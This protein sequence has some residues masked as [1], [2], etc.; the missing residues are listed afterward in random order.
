MQRTLA[1]IG[2]FSPYNFNISPNGSRIS[3]YGNSNGLCIS[4]LG[5]ERGCVAVDSP[6]DLTS[7]NNDGEVLVFSVVPGVCDHETASNFFETAPN[8]GR[9][10]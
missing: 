2:E 6:L 8:S 1:G 10:G 5:G 3:Y 4:G 9:R 7:V